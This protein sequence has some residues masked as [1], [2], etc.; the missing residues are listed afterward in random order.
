M[1]KVD[2]MVLRFL[3]SDSCNDCDCEGCGSASFCEEADKYYDDLG[4]RVDGKLMIDEKEIEEEEN[5]I[6][7]VI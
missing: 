7:G 6:I 4:I 3:E 2:K 1:N 5:K